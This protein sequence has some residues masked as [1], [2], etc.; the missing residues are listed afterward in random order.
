MLDEYLPLFLRASQGKAS[1]TIYLDAFAGEASGIDRITGE[2][3]EG[4]AAIAMKASADQGFT[5]LRFFE[6]ESKA[7]GLEAR[8]HQRYPG[9]DLKVYGGD[10]NVR[11]ADALAEL[12]HIR[13]APTFAFLDPDGMEL[14]WSTLELLAAHKRGYKTGPGPEF[15]IELWML[16]P[17]QGLIRV[18]ALDDA[19]LLP[20]HVEQ[21]T[22]LFG[23]EAWRPIY[24]AR[25]A[26]ELTAAEAK[27]EYVNLMRWRLTKDLGY[28]KTHPFE[29]QNT[30]K[31]LLYTMIFA[32]DNAAG[33]RIMAE[34][35]SKAA[36]EFPIMQQ[37]A[38]DRTRGQFALNFG[39]GGPVETYQH[40]PPNPPYERTVSDELSLD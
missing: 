34:I 35:Y 7:R 26:G 8:L 5:H 39:D 32:T 29:I 38:F 22:R 18:L 25:K 14:A 1:K 27:D 13:W 6:Q 31:G 16:F 10:C 23:C 2:V 20:E 9:R 11:M 24:E 17:T 4:S 40:E 15:K 12:Q 21:A 36:R 19:R 37:E 30:R 28:A 3:F 33:D